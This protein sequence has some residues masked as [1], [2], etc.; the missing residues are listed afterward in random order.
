[1]ALPVQGAKAV[2][3][4]TPVYGGWGAT[5]DKHVHAQIRPQITGYLVRQLGKERFYVQKN[6]ALF[7]I[8]PQT[9]PA[10]LD[11]AKAQLAPAKSQLDAQAADEKQSQA[12]VSCE[13]LQPL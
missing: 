4:E 13:L 3:Q 2:Q 5:L 10:T 11:Q 1:M 7:Q 8:D 12:S 9:S 6:Q